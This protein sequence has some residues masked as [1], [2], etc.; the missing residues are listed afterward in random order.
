MPSFPNDLRQVVPSPILDRALSSS[1]EVGSGSPLLSAPLLAWL[2]ARSLARGM[3]GKRALLS[4]PPQHRSPSLSSQPEAASLAVV[5]ALWPWLRHPLSVCD[6][7]FP[8]CGS[9]ERSP[10]T[11]LWYWWSFGIGLRQERHR[12][13]SK[14]YF[15]L[16]VPFE[17]AA[18]AVL[19]N[20]AKGRDLES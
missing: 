6:C 12:R 13:R 9:R 5:A 7:P 3:K 20:G 14:N 8:Q 11:L 1:R 10:E 19:Q 4:L 2:L 16:T 15:N 18:S 17:S